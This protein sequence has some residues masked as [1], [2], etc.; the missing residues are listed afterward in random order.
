MKEM[1]LKEIQKYSLDILLDVHKFCVENDIKYTL[2]YG[3]LI[4]AIRHKGFIPWD[5]D[6][7]IMMTRENY[8]KFRSLYKDQRYRFICREDNPECLLNFGRVCDVNET[9]CSTMIPWY[10]GEE[11][12]GVWIDIFPMDYIPDDDEEFDHL[13]SMFQF[14]TAQ[15]LAA[16]K[17]IGKLSKGLTTK[18]N[19]KII[20]KK[21]PQKLHRKP[22]FSASDI[23]GMIVD[24]FKITGGQKT[25]SLCQLTTAD[26]VKARF[27]AEYFDNLMTVD[28]EGEKLICTK[29]Y[30]AVLR[31]TYG[32]YMQLPPKKKRRPDQL[33]YLRFYW[34]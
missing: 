9:V 31:K 19:L 13:F 34:K 28:F 21:L 7:D 24:L 30:D 10:I 26:M 20:K 4:G 5:D 2:A 22:K 33:K 3:T 8:D 27:D 16:R 14:M 18:M 6:V 25:K 17:Y 32:D 15:C 23:S 12:T 29:D 1:T 11:S